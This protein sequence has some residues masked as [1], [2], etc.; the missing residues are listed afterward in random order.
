MQ[1]SQEDWPNG[2][3][4][5][6]HFPVKNENLFIYPSSIYARRISHASQR[7]PMPTSTPRLPDVILRRNFTRLSTALG[8]WRP[9]NEAKTKDQGH[10]LA[11]F[12]SHVGLGTR[13]AMVIYTSTHVKNNPEELKVMWCLCMC[14]L[15]WLE[16]YYMHTHYLEGLLRMD[17]NGLK[18]ASEL[19]R[20]AL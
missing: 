9:G 19:T 1:D 20:E 8:D 13:L 6:G 4:V 11:S 7:L 16:T 12:L 18:L 15:F 10:G 17:I 3:W 2:W 5:M 14:F